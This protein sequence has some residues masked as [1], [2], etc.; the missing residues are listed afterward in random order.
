MSACIIPVAPNFQDPP[1][2]PD[3]VPY[4]SG[5]VP[6]SAEIITFLPP[7]MPFSANVTDQNVGATLHY[8]WATDYP[9]FTGVT[10]FTDQAEISPSLDGTPTLVTELVTCKLVNNVSGTHRL[11]LMVADREFKDSSQT[12]L[13]TDNQLDSLID[14]A[15]TGHVVRANWIVV[16]SCPVTSASSMSSP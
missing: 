10:T 8:H 1:S 14:P 4:L 6:T 13:T 7:S 3:T 15:G 12:G 9:P 16:M 11:L 2:V 5:F